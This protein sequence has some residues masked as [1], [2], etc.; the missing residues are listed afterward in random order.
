MGTTEKGFRW[1]E[2]TDLVVDGDDAIRALATDVD[3]STW[4]ASSA[5][6]SVPTGGTASAAFTFPIGRFLSPPWCFGNASTSQG[7]IATPG[8]SP[9]ESSVTMTIRNLNTTAP[10]TIACHLLA[11]AGPADA[12]PAVAAVA[13]AA[14]PLDVWS[15]IIVACV[16]PTCPALGV[17]IEVWYSDDAPLSSI[18]CG[19]CG[20]P[21]PFD[22]VPAGD[23]EE[24]SG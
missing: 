16:T 24:T 18:T 6:V 4:S 17:D 23:G 22:V 15:S 10:Q 8:R 9:S 7:V 11:V 19:S 1:P 3:A 14:A 21:I 2:G 13:A 12:G 20:Q 5:G